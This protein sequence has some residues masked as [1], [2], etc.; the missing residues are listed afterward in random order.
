[1]EINQ[2]P[3][4]KGRICG[5]H[6]HGGDPSSFRG[7]APNQVGILQFHLDGRKYFTYL[8]KPFRPQELMDTIGRLI[9]FG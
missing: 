7:Q 1:M 2:F 4:S 9:N 5:H 6:V 3:A 8:T